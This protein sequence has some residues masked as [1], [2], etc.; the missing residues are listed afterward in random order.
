M[1]DEHAELLEGTLVEEDVDTLA[2]GE[3]A[4]AVLLGDA[5]LAAAEPRPGPP[6][7]QLL[8]DVPH[9]R[10]CPFPNPRPNFED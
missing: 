4:E 9:G 8:Q 10:S 5:L 7:F 2:R 3:L 1:L 6:L